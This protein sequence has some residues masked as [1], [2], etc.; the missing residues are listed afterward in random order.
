MED[1][2]EDSWTLPDH[3]E[4]LDNAYALDS[5]MEGGGLSKMFSSFGKALN[6]I[7]TQIPDIE[8]KAMVGLIL[9]KEAM[10]YIPL[11]KN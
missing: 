1:Q 2:E 3:I 7:K 11:F 5:K 9:Y 6:I 8:V 10:N 4:W